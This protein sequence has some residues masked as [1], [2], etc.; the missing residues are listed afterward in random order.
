MIWLR[1]HVRLPEV[2]GRTSA[3]WPTEEQIVSSD[4]TFS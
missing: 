2:L 1:V 4:L 3:F